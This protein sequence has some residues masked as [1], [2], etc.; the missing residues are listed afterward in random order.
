MPSIVTGLLSYA[1]SEGFSLI[2]GSLIVVAF[3]YMD[4]KGKLG[5]FENFSLPAAL[6]WISCFAF[7]FSISSTKNR[8]FIVISLSMI[9]ASIVFSIYKLL[10]V[11]DN[12]D[13]DM[14]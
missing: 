13:K 5:F 11:I 10:S 6:I 12:Y 1:A 9:I 7:Y 2:I 4:F 14:G 8:Y 3:C